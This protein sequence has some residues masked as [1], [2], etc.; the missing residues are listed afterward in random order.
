MPRSMWS[1]AISFGLVNVPV[2]LYSAVSPKEVHFHMVHDEDGARIKQKRVCSADGK[3]VAWE[4]I[5][6]GYEVSPRRVVMITREELESYDPKATRTIEIQDFV[7][8]EAIDPIFYETTYYLGPD[9]GADKAYALLFEA[10]RRTNKVGIARV[11]L[12]TKQYVCAV[13]PMGDALALSTM[14]YADEIVPSKSIE[15]LHDKSS[16]PGDRELEMAERLVESLSTGWDPKRYKDEYREKILELI[17]RKAKGETIEAPSEEEKPAKVVNLID[18][19]QASLAAARKGDKG[20]Y[21]H[22]EPV[23][24]AA[25]RG[26]ARRKK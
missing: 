11:V 16:K 13:R 5:A 9:R 17:E 20:E 7:E 26:Q 21:R 25:R 2:K 24:M 19:L 14:L 23:K 22:R 4:H 12:R 15:S 10:M 6:K 8:L 18:A 1:G 3:E